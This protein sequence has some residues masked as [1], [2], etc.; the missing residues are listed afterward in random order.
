MATRRKPCRL[1]AEEPISA[2]IL[3]L[4]LLIA[5]AVLGA[6]LV[7]ASVEHGDGDQ[8]WTVGAPR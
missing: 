6:Y 1:P 5:G 8:T 7:A 2:W 4:A 3:P